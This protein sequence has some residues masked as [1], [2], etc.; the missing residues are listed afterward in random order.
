MDE[1]HIQAVGMLHARYAGMEH[2]EKGNR[3]WKHD[4]TRP[5]KCKHCKKETPCHFYMVKEEIPEGLKNK[6]SVEYFTCTIC[7]KSGTNRNRLLWW[8]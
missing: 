1:G 8:D 2:D 4:Y 3:F 6:R 7:G 5:N